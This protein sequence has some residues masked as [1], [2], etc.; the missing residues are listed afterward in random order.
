MHGGLSKQEL[1]Q[2]NLEAL[3]KGCQNLGRHIRNLGYFG[4]PVVVAINAF[5]SD[6]EEEYQ[7]IQ[8]LLSTIQC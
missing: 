8:G 1:N 2:P 4:V 7:L 3:Q 5:D 6:T